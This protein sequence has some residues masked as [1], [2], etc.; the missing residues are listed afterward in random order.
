MDG[1]AGL[2][3]MYRSPIAA[4]VSDR[5]R[6]LQALDHLVE[7]YIALGGVPHILGRLRG[8]CWGGSVDDDRL[9]FRRPF[10]WRVADARA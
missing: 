8:R 10:G 6:G 5:F 7:S 4:Y 3:G 9:I 2:A 1:L